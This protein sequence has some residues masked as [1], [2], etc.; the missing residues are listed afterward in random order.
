MTR[1]QKLTAWISIIGASAV[2]GLTTAIKFFP[3]LTAILTAVAGVIGAFIAFW[4]TKE[5]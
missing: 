5:V 4:T 3:D 1:G 2:A